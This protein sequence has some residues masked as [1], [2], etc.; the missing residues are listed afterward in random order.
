M[1]WDKEKKKGKLLEIIS[2]LFSSS[3][4]II[5]TFI[6]SDIFV[7]SC[8][9]FDPKF[10]T[11]ELYRRQSFDNLK[12]YG[13]GF[14]KILRTKD[15]PWQPSYGVLF[16]PF[17]IR[18]SKLQNVLL[19]PYKYMW[20]YFCVDFGWKIVALHHLLSQYLGNIRDNIRDRTMHK[21]GKTILGVYFC[22]NF[23][24]KGGNR[25]SAAQS[26]FMLANYGN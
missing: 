15:P 1:V 17:L 7:V 5:N 26:N 20:V 14:L 24:W 2:A 18:T 22:V 10:W 9:P 19:C 4:V 16:C 21:S 6:H 13:L 25:W 12:G 11:R 3:L 23:G 8:D